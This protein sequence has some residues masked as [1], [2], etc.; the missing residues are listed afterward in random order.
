MSLGKPYLLCDLAYLILQLEQI[1]E[2]T[3]LL[4]KQ[5]HC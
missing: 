5:L 4:R 2:T 1:F 3:K